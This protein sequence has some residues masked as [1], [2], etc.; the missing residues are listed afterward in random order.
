M[1]DPQM[2]IN[3]GLEQAR[4]GLLGSQGHVLGVDLGGYGLRAVLVDLHERT[5][6]SAHAE[7]A[8]GEPD[9]LVEQTI[10][11]CRGLLREQGVGDGRLVRVGVGFGGPVDSRSGTVLL[12]PRSSGWERYPLREQFERAFD[13]ATIVDN[14]ANLIALGEATFGVGRAVDHLFY[15]HLSSGVGGGAVLDGRLYHGATTTAGEIGHAMVGYG[16]D[17]IG[18][19]A[20]LEQLVSVPGMLARA[21]DLGAHTDNLNDL[22]GQNPAGQQVVRETVSILAMQL[23]QLVVL[24]DPQ[25]VV[26]GGIVVRIG[27]E[28]FVAA[29]RD[30]I[31]RYIQPQFA[32]PV[33][34]VA[35]ALGPE[36]IAVGGVA[37]ALES[38]RD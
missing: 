31:T 35:S 12:S 6:A 25:M 29:V 9:E 2:L 23:A 4:W 15:L 11:L 1:T 20:T 22:F 19:P 27:G 28:P 14:D 26:L 13:A 16:W 38:L 8:G 37:L 21:G 17:G 30:Q 5:V 24:L 33:Q 36:S 3:E 10:A 7:P 18:Q 32:R 34:V